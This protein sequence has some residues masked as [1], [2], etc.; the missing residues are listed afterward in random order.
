[1]GLKHELEAAILDELS[2]HGTQQKAIA[3]K[4]GVH[5]CDVSALRR[6]IATV[7]ISTD[8][9]IA[10]AAA[11]GIGCE[12]KLIKIEPVPMTAVSSAPVVLEQI[13]F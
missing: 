1:M 13:D 9:M 4:F 12:T 7:V 8:K 3:E 10:L 5:Q 11:F 6:G 2:K